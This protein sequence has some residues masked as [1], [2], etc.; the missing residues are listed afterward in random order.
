MISCISCVRMLMSVLWADL[1]QLAVMCRFTYWW[2][3]TR[4]GSRGPTVNSSNVYSRVGA[5]WFLFVCLS[6]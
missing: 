1:G 3:P 6:L 5:A 2:M 4:P